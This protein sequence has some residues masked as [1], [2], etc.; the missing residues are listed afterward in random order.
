MKS[1]KYICIK[2]GCDFLSEDQ[3][4]AFDHMETGSDHVVAEVVLEDG[5]LHCSKLAEDVEIDL[6]DDLEE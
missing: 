4:E 5:K 2:H 6:G 3:S 1:E